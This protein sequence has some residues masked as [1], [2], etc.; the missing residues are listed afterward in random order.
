MIHSL[1]LKK[2]NSQSQLTLGERVISHI[3]LTQ[4]IIIIIIIVISIIL[5]NYYYSLI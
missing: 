4:I 2:N 1:Y 3:I 5:Y